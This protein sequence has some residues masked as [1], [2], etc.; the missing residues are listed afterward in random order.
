MYLFDRPGAIAPATIGT[1]LDPDYDGLGD[2]VEGFGDYVDSDTC[3]NDCAGMGDYMEGG[4][5]LSTDTPTS[6][7]WWQTAVSE[8][9][10]IL[11]RPSIPGTGQ[12]YPIQ[13]PPYLPSYPVSTQT[14]AGGVPY[15]MF[16]QPSNWLPWAIVAGAVL[17]ATRK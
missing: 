6:V 14:P 10:K 9:E 8:I 7:P 2:Y 4:L 15:S 13:T 16:S 5:G 3:C 17:I 11:G 1:Q 12:T